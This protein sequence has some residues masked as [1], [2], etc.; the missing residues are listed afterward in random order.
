[1][2][3]QL[4]PTLHVWSDPDLR[5]GQVDGYSR[6]HL[7]ALAL[8]ETMRPSSRKV[9][10]VEPLSLAWYRQLEDR[11]YTRQGIWLPRLLEFSKHAGERIL[12]LG[13]GLGTDWVRFAQH[14]SRVH[15]GAMSEEQRELV[16]R[17]F[18]LRGLSAQFGVTNSAPLPFDAASMDVVLINGPFLESV[19][20]LAMIAEVFRV[21]KPGGKVL[22]LMPAY[23]DV[24][25]WQNLFLPWYRWI[26]TPRPE[27][28]P[29]RRFTG[30][31]L[32]QW[33][34]AFVDVRIRKRHVRR[35]ELPHLWRCMPLG[36]MERLVGRMLCVK[37]FKPL[38]AAMPASVPAAA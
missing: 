8:A 17:N 20:S 7:E 3:G 19:N 1:M 34:A 10:P 24:N 32:C 13:Q 6:D 2:E 12:G 38:S 9:D 14:G 26:D 5:L 30:R 27:L 37:A 28:R 36:V 25:Y 22:M 31:E 29:E 11:R 16:Q 33:F 4:T 21:L 35:S 15:V 18:V 23:Y